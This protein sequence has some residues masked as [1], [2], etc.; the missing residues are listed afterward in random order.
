MSSVETGCP[1]C[2][3]S[4]DLQVDEGGGRRQS[5]VQDCQVCCQPWQVEVVQ[6]RDGDWS[7]ELR[8]LDE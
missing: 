3:E 5:Y 7:V 8:T 2:G 6:D 4:V 1:Y